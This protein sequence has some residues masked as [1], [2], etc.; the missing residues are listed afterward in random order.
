M[1]VFVEIFAC[2][3]SGEFT[4][5]IVCARVC[6]HVTLQKL[7]VFAV[8]REYSTCLVKLA[9]APLQNSV[10]RRNFLAKAGKAPVP[11]GSSPVWSMKLLA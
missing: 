9:R 10:E 3:F 11:T 4:D 6:I 8:E 2:Y 1:C 5:C 7:M